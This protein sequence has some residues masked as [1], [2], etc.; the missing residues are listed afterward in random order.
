MLGWIERV[1]SRRL[2]GEDWAEFVR[3]FENFSAFYCFRINFLRFKMLTRIIVH[4]KYCIYAMPGCQQ[5]SSPF[6]NIQYLAHY[7]H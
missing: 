6:P 7:Y 5:F 4:K 3:E 2:Q 1:G